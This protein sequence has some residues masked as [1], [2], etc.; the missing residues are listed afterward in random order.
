MARATATVGCKR[1]CK[2]CYAA[3]REG[4]PSYRKK[5]GGEI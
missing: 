1:I 5:G 4:Y 2:P 3:E